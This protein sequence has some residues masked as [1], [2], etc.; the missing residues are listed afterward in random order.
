MHSLFAFWAI[1]Q[2]YPI[3]EGQALNFLV[4]SLVK[5]GGSQISP[6]GWQ[7]QSRGSQTQVLGVEGC[8]ERF[9]YFSC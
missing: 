5:E 1:S 2:A 7:L 4:H 8:Q 6:L 3:L 9:Q